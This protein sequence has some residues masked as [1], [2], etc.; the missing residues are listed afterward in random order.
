LREDGNMPI[1][2]EEARKYKGWEED[3]V[4]IYKFL[5]AH[6]G[7]AY[8][9]EEIRKELGFSVTYI[10]DEKGSYLNL[11]NIGKFVLDVAHAVLFEQ[12][13][14]QM[15]K[16]GKIAASEIAGKKYYFIE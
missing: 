6:K 2:I 16:K 1:R 15:V 5:E 14:E 7:Y 3:E 8:T 10:P 9:S 4:K 12:K 11:Q 13:L